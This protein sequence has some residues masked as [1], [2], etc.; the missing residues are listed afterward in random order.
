MRNTHKF[1]NLFLVLLSLFIS[2]C[3]PIWGQ[4]IRVTEGIKTFT[5]VEG[6]ISNLQPIKSIYV[7]SPFLNEEGDFFMCTSEDG[8]IFP[9]STKVKYVCR[10]DI[11][12]K[13]SAE[14]N[15]ADLFTSE[16]FSLRDTAQ[17]TSLKEML[18][19]KSADELKK[20][21]SL[22]TIPEVIMIG[23]VTALDHSIAPLRGIVTT[24]SFRLDFINVVT[25]KSTVIDVTVKKLDQDTI[26]R[27][28]E[29][30]VSKTKSE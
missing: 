24:I 10:G 9:Y 4:A 18:M 12:E 13:F 22:A 11:P 28:V 3:G 1:R 21:L 30:M 23:S 17:T 16:V 8:T 14:F 19:T 27:V 2:S 15:E 7:L 6:D 20:E 5:V 26:P 29:E 25:K